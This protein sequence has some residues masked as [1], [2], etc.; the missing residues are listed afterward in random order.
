MAGGKSRKT[1]GVSKKLIQR[2][3]KEYAADGEPEKKKGKKD[4]PKKSRQEGFGFDK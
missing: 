1:G 3:V 2:L 4:E